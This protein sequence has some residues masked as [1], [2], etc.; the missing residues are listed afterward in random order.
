MLGSK[1][2]SVVPTNIHGISS[3]GTRSYQHSSKYLLLFSA[4]QR[5][6]FE[7]THSQK[8]GTK[9]KLLSMVLSRLHFRF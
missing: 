8:K 9:G 1:Q 7:T 6:A 2:L 4:E 3:M 5:N